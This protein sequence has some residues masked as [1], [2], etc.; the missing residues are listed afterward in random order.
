MCHLLAGAD[1]PLDRA[2][3]RFA[4][5]LRFALSLRF[6]LAIFR[7]FRVLTPTLLREQPAQNIINGLRIGLA[8]GCLHHLADKK[9]EDAFIAS[10]EFRDIVWILCDNVASS[11]LN[12]GSI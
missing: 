10:L 1:L 11:L 12:R 6:A 4:A 5:G 2:L 8:A 9:L 7:H 3:R